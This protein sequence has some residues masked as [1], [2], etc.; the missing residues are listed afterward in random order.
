MGLLSALYWTTPNAHKEKVRESER[1]EEEENVEGEEREN[2]E[3]EE[4]GYSGSSFS[5]RFR[6]YAEIRS[7][8]L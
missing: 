1:E 6:Y 7:S 5:N 4:G 2:D 8:V 3:T